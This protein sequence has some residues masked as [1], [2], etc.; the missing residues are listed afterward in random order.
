LFDALTA[1]TAVC[2]TAP[3]TITV[4]NGLFR[5]ALDDTCTAAVQ[6]NPNLFVEV[7]VNS[8]TMQPRTKL[9]AVPYAIESGGVAFS[10]VRIPAGTAWPG[11]TTITKNG[12]S[13]SVN[14]SFCGSSTATNGNAGGYTGAKTMCETACSSTTAH[15]CTSEEMLRSASL[16]L[17]LPTLGWYAGGLQVHPYSDSITNTDCLG[18]TTSTSTAYGAIWYGAG[19]MG[20][21]AATCDG[22]RPLL[23]C[24]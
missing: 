23:C 24:D 20:A 5:I 15:L 1:G 2:S 3:Q 11:P 22:L 9:G 6:A 13:Y 18:F 14:G 19:V 12:K 10:N 4:T 16:G 8:Q 7:S 17:T 21:T